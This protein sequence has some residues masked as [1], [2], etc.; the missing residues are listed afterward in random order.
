MVSSSDWTKEAIQAFLQRE[1]LQF[2][3][4]TLPYGLTTPGTDRKSTC[5]LIFR[6][7]LLG[8]SVLDIGSFL[9]YFCI[10]AAER[11]A[12]RVVG[13]EVDSERIRQARIIAE[14]K[15]LAIEYVQHDIETAELQ[16]DFDVVLCLNILHHMFNPIA[17]LDKLI[18]HTREKLILEVAAVGRH[19]RRKLGVSYLQSLFISKT[20]VIVTGKGSTSPPY[21]KQQKYF[22]TKQALLNLLHYHRNYWRP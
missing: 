21:N 12:R 8:K 9:G 7:N 15:G 18:K 17:V 22:F 10:E 3:K 13:W 6:D 19:D 11:E 20:P 2:Q 4:I 14:I 1:D 5:E 16:E